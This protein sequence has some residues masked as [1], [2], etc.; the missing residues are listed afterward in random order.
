M[1]V[2]RRKALINKLLFV[3]SLILTGCFL[4][5]TLASLKLCIRN[6][7]NCDDKFK[8]KKKCKKTEKLKSDLIRFMFKKNQN[9][10]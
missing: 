10:K 5:V 3:K 8:K 1:K 9:D 2:L 4:F 6:N 7:D